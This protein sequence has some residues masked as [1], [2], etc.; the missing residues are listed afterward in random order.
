MDIFKTDKSKSGLIDLTQ[1]KQ[2]KDLKSTIYFCSKICID[3][4]DENMS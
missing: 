1:G 4:S 3:F 2:V